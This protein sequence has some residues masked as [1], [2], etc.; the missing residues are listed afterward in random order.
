MTVQG[1]GNRDVR[2]PFCFH[3][4]HNSEFFWFE[5]LSSPFV[6]FLKNFKSRGK[7]TTFSFFTGVFSYFLSVPPH[8]F[9]RRFPYFTTGV[10]NHDILLEKVAERIQDEEVLHLIKVIC[11]TAG[12]RGVPQGGVLSPLLA[13]IYLNEVDKML[14]KAKA[15]TGAVIYARYADDLV[16]L[17]KPGEWLEKVNRRLLEELARIKVTVNEEKSQIVN[18]EEGKSFNFLGFEFRMIKGRNGKYRPDYKPNRK[19]RKTLLEKLRLLFKAYESK[20]IEGLV[21]KANPILRGWLNYFRIGNSSRAF[22]YVRNWVERKLRRHAMKARQRKGYGWKRWSREGIVA[23]SG[24]YDD[25]K[26]RYYR[27]KALTG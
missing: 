6:C 25:Y 17:V 13:N 9:N 2:V 23:K 18:M 24:I 20:P 12:K 27:P 14:E 26:I 19:A 16:V 15:V 7:Y 4:L 8:I 5:H 3:L 1:Q 22:G 10:D 11:Q 21:K